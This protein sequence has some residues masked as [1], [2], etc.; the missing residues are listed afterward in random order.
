MLRFRSVGGIT[1]PP[2]KEIMADQLDRPTN[3]HTDMRVHRESH[4]SS[5]GSA[6]TCDRKLACSKLQFASV[7]TVGRGA[8]KWIS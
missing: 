7:I 5:A 1:S 6:L 2:F 4:N 3:Q 8:L